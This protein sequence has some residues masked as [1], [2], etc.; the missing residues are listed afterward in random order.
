MEHTPHVMLAGSGADAFAK[1]RGL[2]ATTLLTL[3]AQQSYERWKETGETPEQATDVGLRPIDSTD[4][5]R[6]F[7]PG[8][9]RHHDTVGVLAIDTA[10]MLA[11]GCSTSGMPFKMPGRVGDSPIIGH[12]LYVDPD[13][14]AVTATGDGELIMRCCGAMSVIEAM[15][16]GQS[17]QEA[18]VSVLNRINATQPITSKT[19]V[20]FIVMTPDGGVAT[21]ALRPGFRSVVGT[22]DA[23]TIIEPEVV[24]RAD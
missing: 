10:G 4:D 12:G 7:A 15:R 22:S 2:P 3:Q 1:E 8:E 6:L 19:Q 20:A 16:H 9:Q 13:I 21:A 23:V 5:G 18:I 17:A 11:G 24:I 14:G